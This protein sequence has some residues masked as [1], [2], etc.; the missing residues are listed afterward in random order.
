MMRPSIV[1]GGNLVDCMFDDFFKDSFF[2]S[3]GNDDVKSITTDILNHEDSFE[4][5]M[6]LPGFSAEDVKAELKDGYMTISADHSEEKEEEDEE[7]HYIRKE[8]YSGSYRRNFYVGDAVTQDD[9]KA[10]YTEGVL[11]VT[12]PKVEKKVE[13]EEKKLISIES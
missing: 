9:I 11:T 7:G 3:V 12:V 10:K 8:R 5:K 6:D 2:R 13:E 1:Y 4:I